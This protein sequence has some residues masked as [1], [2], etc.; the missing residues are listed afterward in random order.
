MLCI[1]QLKATHLCISQCRAQVVDVGGG[2]G[3]CTQGIVKAV[4]AHNVTLIDQSP[5]QLAK[6]KKKPDLQG[7]TILEVH[8]ALGLRN[9]LSGRPSRAVCNIWLLTEALAP[10]VSQ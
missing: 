10:S 3:F 9:L 5:H 7:A 6:A 1:T 4:P 2:T 8:R